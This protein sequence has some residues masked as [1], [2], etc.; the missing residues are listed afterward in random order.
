MQIPLF[1][2]LSRLSVAACLIA[3]ANVGAAAAN[4]SKEIEFARA[5]VK[6]K[7]ETERTGTEI[8][9][10]NPDSGIKGRLQLVETKILGR[11]LACRWYKWS[12]KLDSAT[13]IETPEVSPRNIVQSFLTVRSTNP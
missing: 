7:L 3:L 13:K 12:V 5:V 11:G 2:Y 8:D 4:E 9:W 6:S 10:T 1:Y